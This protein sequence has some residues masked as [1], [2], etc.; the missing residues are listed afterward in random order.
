MLVS[1]AA[2]AAFTLPRDSPFH[3]VSVPLEDDKNLLDRPS[4]LLQKQQDQLTDRLWLLLLHPM[5][6]AIE[7]V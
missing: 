2:Y 4:D 7:E 6:G 3:N 1:A 5:A